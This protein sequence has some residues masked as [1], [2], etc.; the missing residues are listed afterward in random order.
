MPSTWSVVGMNWIQHAYPPRRESMPPLNSAW[1]YQENR[2]QK[3]VT[4]RP[5][6]GYNSAIGFCSGRLVV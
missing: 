1:T 4:T 3:R 2:R 6:F 5:P